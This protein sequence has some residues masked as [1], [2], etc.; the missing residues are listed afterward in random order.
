MPDCTSL[1]LL[2]SKAWGVPRAPGLPALLLAAGMALMAWPSGLLQAQTGAVYEPASYASGQNIEGSGFGISS[3]YTEVNNDIYITITPLVEFPLG[4]IKIGLQIPLEVLVLD[5]DPKGEE[6]VPSLRFGTYDSTEDYL[7][8]IAYARYGT[9]LYFDPD[10]DFNWSFYF[11]KLF[12]GWMG[13]KTIIFR[14]QNNF[15]PAFYRAGV[16]ADINNRWGGLEYFSSDIWRREVVGMRGYIRPVG[17]IVGIQNMLVHGGGLPSLNQVALSLHERRDPALNG[18]VFYQEKIPDQKSEGGRLEQYFYGT[19]G[20]DLGRSNLQF[21]EVINPQTGEV[22]VRAKEEPTKPPEDDDKWE[23][24]GRSWWERFAIGY[25]IVRDLDAPLILETD[26]S[27]NLVV[28]PVT[29]RP[30]GLDAE[31]LTV[32]GYDAELRMSPF[33]WLDLTPYIDYN[34]FKHIEGAEG[35]HVGIDAGFKISTFKFTLRPEYR[36][37]AA[38]YIPTYFDQYHAIERTVYQPGGDGTGSGSGTE[39]TKLAYLKTLDQDGERVEGYFIL[40][41]F[42]WLQ[43]LV[44][45]ATYEDYDGENNS[46]VFV[47]VYVP[48][49]FNFYFNGYYTKKDFEDIT[50]SFEY[51]DRSLA[52]A[53]L[54]YS[55]FGGISATVTFTRTWVYDNTEAAYVAQDEI[56]YGVGFSASF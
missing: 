55:F 46:K 26:G 18:G 11:G 34:Q 53:Q 45:E 17:A 49:A 54:G 25:S 33:S 15:D 10:D 56:S 51:D 37:H 20:E 24:W 19:I 47:G 9:H 21:E 32:I 36:E 3:G 44:I 42:E 39:V 40:A 4:K 31:N 52:A 12:D 2:L 41:M 13:H 22:E 38:N 1:A 23:K 7:K 43:T 48:A 29:G 28:D 6:D 16:M 14:Y 5:R 30:R 27:S 35:Y 50:E 8:L